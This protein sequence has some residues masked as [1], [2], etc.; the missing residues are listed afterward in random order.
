MGILLGH[1]GHDINFAVADIMHVAGEI[2][3]DGHAQGNLLHHA[4]LS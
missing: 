2:A 4:D 1:V 3:Q